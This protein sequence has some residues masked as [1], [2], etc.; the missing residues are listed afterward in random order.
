MNDVDDTLVNLSFALGTT[1]YTTPEY[2]NL[3][4]DLIRVGVLTE[5]AH[6][7]F[8]IMEPT[9]VLLNPK[10]LRGYT[11]FS[12][13]VY[14]EA[15]LAGLLEQLGGIRGVPYLM[16]YITDPFVEGADLIRSER[17]TAERE[18]KLPSWMRMFEGGKSGRASD[19]E[20]KAGEGVVETDLQTGAGVQMSE[21]G[22]L[23]LLRPDSY[24]PAG[25]RHDQAVPAKEDD[26]QGIDGA[27]SGPRTGRRG[28]RGRTDLPP[29]GQEREVPSLPSPP[30]TM[31]DDGK[32][33][34]SERGRGHGVPRGPGQSNRA[35][36]GILQDVQRGS[37]VFRSKE[38]DSLEEE[39]FSEDDEATDT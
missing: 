14:A 23:P 9:G 15:Y 33:S 5:K 18:R 11:Y 32:L 30:V 1:V 25:T 22:M 36:P 28:E 29:G 7:V 19:D 27:E 24:A 38:S 37:P 12:Q 17:E 20:Q 13:Q 39:L 21:E 4:I 8:A 26:T 34:E 6:E 31:S 35:N 10:W 16:V 2:K 3:V